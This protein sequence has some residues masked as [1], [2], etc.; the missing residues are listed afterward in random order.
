MAAMEAPAVGYI[1]NMMIAVLSGV[2][3]RLICR[4]KATQ[5]HLSAVTY[6][7]IRQVISANVYRGTPAVRY[8]NSD[9][10]IGTSEFSNKGWTQMLNHC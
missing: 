3:I 2:I 4:G 9:G 6:T 7:V 8:W 5:R 10:T 1:V